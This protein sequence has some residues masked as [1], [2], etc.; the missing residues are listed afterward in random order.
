MSVEVK[1]STSWVIMPT[2]IRA[3]PALFQVVPGR[4]AAVMIYILVSECSL[5]CAGYCI[6]TWGP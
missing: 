5:S 6:G 4:G 3:T 1:S 2:A